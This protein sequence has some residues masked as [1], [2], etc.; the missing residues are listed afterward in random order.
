M[1]TAHYRHAAALGAH[2]L[3]LAPRLPAASVGDGILAAEIC[4]ST[5]VSRK[6]ATEA[7]TA[8]A[9]TSVYGWSELL[10]AG[11]ENRPE[12]RLVISGRCFS[13]K[14]NARSL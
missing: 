3:A 7:G 4:C 13:N 2:T 1:T 8:R 10:F 5:E 11:W 9:E 6:P 12:R 14:N